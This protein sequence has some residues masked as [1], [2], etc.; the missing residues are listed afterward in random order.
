MNM[1]EKSP[2]KCHFTSEIAVSENGVLLVLSKFWV[3]PPSSAHILIKI[4]G[5]MISSK[6]RLRK[7]TKIFLSENY[8]MKKRSSENA[9]LPVKLL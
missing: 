3:E 5:E 4:G 8:F 6:F 2:P 7:V 1:L 9:L